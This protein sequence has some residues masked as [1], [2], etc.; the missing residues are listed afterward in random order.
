MHNQFL[1]TKDY[2]ANAKF[3]ESYARYDHEKNRYETW[4]E[5][6]DRVMGM[7]KT[8][9]K[10]KLS[11][12]LLQEIDY[13]S[14]LYKQKRILGAQRTLQ[15]G[16]DQILKKNARLYNC[17]STYIDR[18]EVFGQIFWFLLCGAGVGFSVQ[19]HHIAK[20]PKVLPRTKQPKL[21]VVEDS[22]E[23]WASALDVLMSSYF[24]TGGKHPEFL[25]RKVY[26]DFSQ[27]R[28]KGAFISGGF[29]A[30][31]PEPLRDALNIIENIMNEVAHQK[32]KLKPIEA[33][34][35][36]MH[37]SDAV[38]AG[39]VRRSATIV[40][41]SLDDFEMMNAKIGN[42]FETNPQ[43]GRSNNSVVL[44]RDQVTRE[45]FAQ[46][47]KSTKE[48]GEPG[49]AF[50]DSTEFATNPCFEI[51]M[52]PQ[53]DGKSGFQ[54][55]NL[56]EINGGKCDTE[57]EFYE[58]CRAASIIGT[59]QAGYTDFEFLGPVSEAIFRREALLGVSITGFMNNPTI[60]LNEE[61][62]R[63]G[64]RI[65]KETNK[66]IAKMIGINPAART[67]CTKPSGNASVLLSTASGI[68][69]E[70]SPLYIRNVQMNKQSE[71]AELFMSSNPYMVEDSIWSKNKTDIIISFPVVS[72]PSSLF[73]QELLGVKLL[74]KVKLVQQSWVEEGTD[75]DLCVDKRLR[76]N[77]SNTISVDDW[78]A[79]EK[80]LFENR[81][82]FA[83][84]SLLSVSGD[85]DFAQAPFT[86]VLT[87]E[88]IVDQYGPAAMF[89]SG[90]IVDALSAYGN[91]W[92][93]VDS[94]LYDS[95]ERSVHE[96]AKEHVL[97][98]D[99]NRRFV[100]YALTYFKGDIK[101]ASYCLKDVYNLHKWYK[102]Q[103]NFT[104]FSWE[105]VLTE[106]EYT[107]INTMGAAACVGVKD[108]EGCAI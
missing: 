64:A 4:D 36:I 26:F 60:L 107:D 76:H 15:F 51:G 82:Y 97:K 87:T 49:F 83:G 7:H 6:V 67:T 20:L 69:G 53:I 86:E 21:Y 12:E 100:K 9:Y 2:M 57:E 14:K 16:G 73:K 91:L 78:N 29:K 96:E 89:A 99:W 10:D 59:L 94:V 25:G 17:T 44:I 85:K 63:K 38:L 71:I 103:N 62:L 80:Y 5:A 90:L 88:Q 56:T 32:R 105:G 47:F 11:D 13:A 3:Y 35:I 93:A 74:E 84:V 92:T 23:G 106:K 28:K 31:G 55:C 18:E 1:D 101:K 50:F 39:G 70:N 61:I 19:K 43:R 98:N 33:Y 66:K 30:P 46:I 104:P 48:F 40:L 37:A 24:E 81:N 58:A 75:E 72:H 34:D 42:W 65:V 68:H 52:L 41:F 77:V 102:I 79:V 45:Q 8:K 27:I 108:G 54:G 22:I 95:V